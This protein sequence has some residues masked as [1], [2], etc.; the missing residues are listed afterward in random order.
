MLCNAYATIYYVDDSA[1]GCGGSGCSDSNNGTSIATAFKTLGHP[2]GLTFNSGDTINL[3]NGR[4]WREAFTPSTLSGVTL[5]G[6]SC[7]G[8]VFKPVISGADLVSSSWTTCPGSTCGGSGHIYSTSVSTQVGRVYVD[9]SPIGWG[10]SSAACLANSSCSAG[11]D[12]E[13]GPMMAGSFYW[14]SNTLYV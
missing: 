6:Y 4:L 2:S 12:N 8:N 11:G 5:T 3:C 9:S 14:S 10:L 7:D 1:T 13:V